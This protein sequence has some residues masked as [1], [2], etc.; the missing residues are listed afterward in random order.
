VSTNEVETKARAM[1][2]LPKDQF[3][4][5]EENWLAADK[6]VERGEAIMPILQANN[7]KLADRLASAEAELQSTKHLLSSATEAIEELKNFRTTLNKDKVKEKKTEVLSALATAKRDGDVEAEVQLT[8]Q[9]TEV[10][11]ALKEADKAPPA[12]P[13]N[14]PALTPAAQTWMAQNPWFGTDKRKT[15]LAMA[16]SDEWRGEGKMLGTPQFFEH[17][18][19]ELGKIFDTNAARREAP[20][21]VGGSVN[22]GGGASEG[23]KTFADLPSEAKDACKRMAGRL[24][25]EGRA[26]KT[27][28]AWQKAYVEQYDW[29]AE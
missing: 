27:M 15:A 20:S 29:R 5:S 9:L 13:A 23:G 6:Y 16:V 28:D 1:G 10:N 7:R 8:D 18:D 12:A 14:T 3:R 24:V 21:K 11:A 4:G 19:A 26:Y 25:G 22:S 17:V 2:W